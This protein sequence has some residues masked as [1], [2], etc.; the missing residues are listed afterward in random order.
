[1]NVN[2]VGVGAGALMAVV[3]LPF[4]AL[5][6]AAAAAPTFDASALFDTDTSLWPEGRSGWLFF[7]TLV[8]WNNCG[9]DSAGMVAGEVAA[10]R[11]SYPRALWGALAATV[12]LYVLPL[13]ACAAADHDW[14]KWREGQFLALA[15]EFGGS[16]L[17]SAMTVAFGAIRRNSA[18]TRRNSDSHRAILPFT[19]GVDRLDG[20]RAVH[21]HVHHLARDLRDVPAA[22]AAGAARTP[23]PGVGH[24][25][26]RRRDER[27]AHL[28]RRR[29]PEFRSAA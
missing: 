28:R 23:P 16:W 6:L 15:Q 3:S 11:S 27:R 10:P 2:L 22:D 7:A 21:A 18:Q 9:Y 14:R 25:A 19:G 20:R 29:L 8:L 5:A 17:L 24:A 4:V 26:R 13:A 12:P 1:M